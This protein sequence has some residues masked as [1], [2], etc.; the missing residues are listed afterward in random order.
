MVSLKF[1]TEVYEF[2]ACKTKKYQDRYQ[3]QYI[4][5]QF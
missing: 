1:L 4:S 5:Q 3:K 2:F